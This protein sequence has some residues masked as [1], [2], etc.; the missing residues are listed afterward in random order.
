MAE[1]MTAA[2]DNCL[3]IFLISVTV[4]QEF[5]V[6]SLLSDNLHEI[7]SLIWDLKFCLLQS[8]LVL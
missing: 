8:S 3:T 4:R 5:H 1:V 2:D 6:N 7:S